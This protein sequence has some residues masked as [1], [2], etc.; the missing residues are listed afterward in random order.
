M[1]TMSIALGIVLAAFIIGWV[2]AG[3]TLEA[4]GYG[5]P[6]SDVCGERKP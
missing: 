4:R 3:I 6:P 1:K 2:L 5:C